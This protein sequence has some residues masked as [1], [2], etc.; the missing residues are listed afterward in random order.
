MT[1]KV[2]EVSFGGTTIQFEQGGA[3]YIRINT[4]RNRIVREPGTTVLVNLGTGKIKVVDKNTDVYA[5]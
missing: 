5:A 1:M 2:K 3:R 4:S